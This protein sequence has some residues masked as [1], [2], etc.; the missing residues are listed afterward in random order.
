MSQDTADAETTKEIG[1]DEYDPIGTLVLI[2]I[3]FVILIV[4]WSFTYFIEFL[5]RQT[6]VG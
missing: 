2:G 4:M 1:H 3:Y 5:G 6:V